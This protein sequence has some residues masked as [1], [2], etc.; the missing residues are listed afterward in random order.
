VLRLRR[1]VEKIEEDHHHQCDGDP[2]EEI[3]GEIIQ[4]VFLR[5]VGTGPPGTRVSAGMNATLSPREKKSRGLDGFPTLALAP[6][7]W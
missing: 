4:T 7:P 6:F 3:F 5:K 2:D 1:L